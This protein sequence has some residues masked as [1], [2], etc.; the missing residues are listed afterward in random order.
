M[1]MLA[2]RRVRA[3][4]FEQGFNIVKLREAGQH[5]HGEVPAARNAMK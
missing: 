3:F 4:T 2:A 1:Y 5:G